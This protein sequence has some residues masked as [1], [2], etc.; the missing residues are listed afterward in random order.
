MPGD[1]LRPRTSIDRGPLEEPID[2]DPQDP[3]SLDE[4][5]GDS[6]A[7]DMDANIGGAPAT[8]G[9]DSGGAVGVRRG[10]AV[11][12]PGYEYETVE[13]GETTSDVPLEPVVEEE[14]TGE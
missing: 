4:S 8:A 10:R 12:R 5:G 6:A 1:K 9:L 2:L 7:S 11:G 14:T 13:R 3:E